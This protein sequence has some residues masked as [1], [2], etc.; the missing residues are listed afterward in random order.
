MKKKVLLFILICLLS[1]FS[2][3][4]S[5]DGNTPEEDQWYEVAGEGE[6]QAS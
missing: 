1:L 3:C 2:G 5:I 4:Q 6:D